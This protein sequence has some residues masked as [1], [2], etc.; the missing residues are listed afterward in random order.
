MTTS[1]GSST[2][3]GGGQ[4]NKNQGRDKSEKTRFKHD[5]IQPR[6]VGHAVLTC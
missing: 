6:C 5:R 4:V 3:H 2:S 1:S